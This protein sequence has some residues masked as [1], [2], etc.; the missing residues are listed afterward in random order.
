[1]KNITIIIKTFLREKS[2]FRLLDSIE[3]YNNDIKIIIVDDG[4]DDL[5]LKLKTKYEL[6]IKYYKLDYDLGLSYGRN[7]ALKMLKTKYFLLCDDDFVF[8]EETNIYKL[9]KLLEEND[10]D[11]VGGAIRNRFNYTEGDVNSRIKN[12]IKSFYKSSPIHNYYGEII[13]TEKELVVKYFNQN[14]FKEFIK[15]DICLNFFLAKTEKIKN[16]GGWNERLKIGEHT[17]FFIRMKENNLKVLTTY[18]CI[19]DHY[20]V[21]TKEYSKYRDRIEEMTRMLF[22]TRSL[23]KQTSIFPEKKLQNIY[24]F[25]N[26]RLITKVENYAE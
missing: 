11:I 10:A 18:E 22:E 4:I 21:R 7:Y 9:K 14:N 19:C 26:G 23:N 12:L 16:A 25:K 1:M 17:D 20:P 3:K 24:Y 2:L 6:D 8:T 13:K 5:R 15:T